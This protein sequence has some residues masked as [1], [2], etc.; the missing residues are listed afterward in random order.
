MWQARYDVAS[1][2]VEQVS[3]RL[4]KPIPFDFKSFAEHYN[5]RLAL[6]Y[7]LLSNIDPGLVARFEEQSTSPDGADLEIQS[8]RYYPLQTTAAHLLG[9]VVRDISSAE[10]EESFFTYRLPDYR[11]ENGVGTEYAFDAYLRGHAGVKSVI[12]NNQGYRQ[13]ETV[14]EPAEPGSNVMLTIDLRIQRVVEQA[15]AS[16]PVLYT[17]PVRGAA[18]VMDVNTGDVLA[19]AS[20]PAYDPNYYVDQHSFPSDYYDQVVQSMGAEKDRATQERYAPGSIFKTIVGLACLEEGMDPKATIDNP[21]YIYV[22]RDSKPIHDLAPPGRYDFKRALSESSNTYFIS[23]GLRYAGIEDI[24]KLGQRLH[25]GQRIGLNNNQET[26]GSFPTLKQ[27]QS[28]WWAGDTANIC[29]GQG[30]IA[31]T[32]LQMTIM[33][34]ALANGGR[35]LYPR[36]VDR[37]EPADSTKG[38][39]LVYPK[40]RIRDYL[41]VSR[42]SLDVLRDA[43]HDEVEEGTGK[44]AAIPGFPICGKTGTAEIKDEHGRATGRTTWFLSFAPMDRPRY[45]VVVMVENGSFGGPTCAPAAKKIYEELIKIEREPAPS[46]NSLARN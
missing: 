42:R 12:V 9:H 11:G 24:V 28:H 19:L 44:N 21:G 4:Q 1:K 6:P 22:G 43:M 31:V 25:L 23:N 15:L 37:I 34:A 32:P 8:A 18:V 7:P 30:Y 5:K 33:A 20:S 16:A 13:S 14:W 3:E 40:G 35:V 45:A 17:P 27:I 2:V 39:P 10:G 29:I 26:P 46:P 41:G 38:P 36:F